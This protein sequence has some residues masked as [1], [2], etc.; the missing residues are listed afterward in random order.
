VDVG[1]SSGTNMVFQLLLSTKIDAVP[2]IR[3]YIVDE[4]RA[5]LDQRDPV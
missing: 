5:L 1:F 4:L 3:D 2:I